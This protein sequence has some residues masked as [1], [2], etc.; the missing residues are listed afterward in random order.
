VSWRE[1]ARVSSASRK[2]AS[3]NLAAW[4]V[5]GVVTL[6]GGAVILSTFGLVLFGIATSIEVLAGLVRWVVG[7]VR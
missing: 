3:P 4:L 2:P 5:A 7:F 6:F 1:R